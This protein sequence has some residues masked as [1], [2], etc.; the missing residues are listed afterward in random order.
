MKSIRNFLIV[1]L[2]SVICLVNFVGALHG[3]QRSMSTA[4]LLLSRQLQDKGELLLAFHR[5]SDKKNITDNGLTIEL[6]QLEQWFEDD[7]L[8]Q[9]W[10][11]ETLLKRSENAPQQPFAEYSQQRLATQQRYYRGTQWHYEFV[12]DEPLV[13]VVAQQQGHYSNLVETMIVESIL[14]I[15]WVLPIIG[16]LIWW[17]VKYGLSPLHRLAAIL[18]L[19]NDRDLTAL[20]QSHY[21][22][23]ISTVVVAINQLLA[24]LQLALGRE[25]RFAADAAHELRTPLAALK[26][27]LHNLRRDLTSSPEQRQ[28]I[29]DALESSVDRMSHS[30]EQILALHRFSPEQFTSN[31]QLCDLTQLA[32]DSIAECYPLIENKQQSIALQGSSCEID[33]DKFGL[34]TLLRNLIDN[35]SKY[36]PVAGQIT[37]TVTRDSDQVI[38]TVEDSG[39]GIAE[40]QRPQVTARFYRVGG[41]RHRS[42]VTGSGLGLSITESIAQLHGGELSLQRSTKL[43][44][45]CCKI[46]FPVRQNSEANR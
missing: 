46:T 6:E 5:Q 41:D 42:G 37:V 31:V 3:Y 15:I 12:V 29:M 39:P 44:G 21:P 45:L 24:R 36:T 14:P 25:R 7:L 4:E 1:V 30:I 13:L 35:A 11:G 27:N 2:L 40:D 8:F 20:N 18:R 19:R 10:H 16:L 38:L 23:E 9:I 43:G 28:T 32:R 33:G 26:V 34:S 22:V 17:V